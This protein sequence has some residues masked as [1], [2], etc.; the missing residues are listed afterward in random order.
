MDSPFNAEQ[1][2][3]LVQNGSPLLVQALGRIFGLGQNERGELARN[4]LPTWAWATLAGA[5]GLATGVAVYRM[6]PEQ[7]DKVLGKRGA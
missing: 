7:V 4:G 3:S 6:W 5:A 1:L 2:A